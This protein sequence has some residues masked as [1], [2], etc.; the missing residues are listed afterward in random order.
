MD[1]G[2]A[3]HKKGEVYRTPWRRVWVDSNTSDTER[4]SE[5]ESYI[6]ISVQPADMVLNS[7]T[8]T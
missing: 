2:Q 5:K 3:A 1:W 6:S 8:L 7:T 4:K